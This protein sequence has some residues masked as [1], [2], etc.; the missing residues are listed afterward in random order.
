MAMEGGEKGDGG[1]WRKGD[2]GG[3]GEGDGVGVWTKT[4]IFCT[5]IYDILYTY[6]DLGL[7]FN[8]GRNIC[9]VVIHPFYSRV[10]WYLKSRLGHKC[11]LP[12]KFL[13]ERS[14]VR[15]IRKWEFCFVSHMVLW[16]VP[17]VIF[18]D[19]MFLCFWRNIYSV[20]G[21]VS[22]PQISQLVW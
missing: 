15:K 2:G 4:S 18:E 22:S 5:Y 17:K 7:S 1:G 19:E 12:N 13:T 3:W 20:L 6:F 10:G 16:T 21:N 14:K 8:Q 9:R 11:L